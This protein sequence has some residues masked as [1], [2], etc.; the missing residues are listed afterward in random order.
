MKSNLVSK[1]GRALTG[2]ALAFLIVVMPL[3][4]FWPILERDVAGIHQEL[5]GLNLYLSDLA[6]LLLLVS[7]LLWI[8]RSEEPHPDTRFLLYPV[9]LLVILTGLSAAW[10]I[11][12]PLAL[13]ILLRL[14]L[15]LATTLVIVRLRPDERIVVY[16]ATLTIGIQALA[17]VMQFRLQHDLGL[18]VLGEPDLAPVPGGS[19][20]LA[21][22]D[23]F[24]LRGYGLTPHPNILGGMLA[25]LLLMLTPSYLRANTKVKPLWSA[26]LLIG[27]AG[28]LVSFSR[29]AWL[30]V[31]AGGIFFL[32]AVWTQK[33]WRV[34]YLRPLILLLF[35]GSILS[36]AVAW[37]NLQ[38]V[39]GR[40]TPESS[41]YETR[42]MSER[43]ILSDAGRKL[44]RLSPLTGVG[45]GNFTP[46]ALP[47][48]AGAPDV[49]PQPVH[50]ML[51]LLSAELGV[52]GGL[53]WLWIMVAPAAVTLRR[54]RRGRLTLFALGISAALVAY[55][56]IDLFDYYAWGWVQGRWLRW[57]LWALWATAIADT[58]SED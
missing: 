33:R 27:L 16:G 12:F 36:F 34:A 20:I 13:L 14:L 55:G 21:A 42:S 10:A 29:S 46:A 44:F 51:L 37:S 41:R 31:F 11:D 30:G 54:L 57:L 9:S 3:P 24:W 45:A 25:S 39:Q 56:V 58:P 32:V 15:L 47:L 17:A 52:G 26:L 6:M 38:L 53:L 22:E 18:T 5:V 23:R 4:R 7:A 28:L 43:Q 50:N 8:R 48:V 1:I 2:A 49:T 19:S 40:L 35:C